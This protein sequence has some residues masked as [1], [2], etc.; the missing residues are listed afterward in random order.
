MIPLEKRDVMIKS[1]W[2]IGP[3]LRRSLGHCGWSSAKRLPSH[4]YASEGSLGKDSP[5]NTA[6]L[7]A[8][9]E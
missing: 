9:V 4:M 2:V 8:T 1:R 7:D 5:G 6:R 3:G